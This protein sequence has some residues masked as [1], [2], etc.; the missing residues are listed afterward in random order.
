[1]PSPG[2]EGVL[3]TSGGRGSWCWARSVP[4]L[5]YARCACAWWDEGPAGYAAGNADEVISMG[6][7]AQ[8]LGLIIMC[9]WASYLMSVIFISFMILRAIHL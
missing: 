7:L 6:V 9:P 8:L 4:G 5:L 2:L 1:M 3:V